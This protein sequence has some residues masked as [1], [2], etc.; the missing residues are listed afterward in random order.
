MYGDQLCRGRIF[1]RGNSWLQVD[2]EVKLP[3]LYLIDSIVKNVGKEYTPLFTQNIVSTFCSVFEKVSNFLYLYQLLP[4]VNGEGFKMLYCL[5][6]LL[7]VLSLFPESV[8]Y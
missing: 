2:P 7:L 1:K 6:C 5:Y 4:E 8:V 3:V